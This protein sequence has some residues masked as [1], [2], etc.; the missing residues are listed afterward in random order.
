MSPLQFVRVFLPFAFGYFISYFFRNVNAIIEQDLVRELGFSAAALGLLT[1]VYFISFAAFQL[2]LGL[3]LDR[4]GP[5]RTESALLLFA[6]LGAFVFS[7]ADSLAGLIVGRLLIGFGVSA[8]LMAAFKAFVLWFP[9]ERLPLMNGLQMVAGG[10]GALSATVPLQQ[11]LEL[12]DWRGVFLLLAGMTV[13]ASAFLWFVLPERKAER[14]SVSLREQLAGLKKVAASPVFWSIAPLTMFSQ[15]AQMAIQGLWAKPWLRD[16]AGLDAD[17]AARHLLWMMVAMMAGFFMLG[18]I[19]E[20]ITRL[21]NIRPTTLGVLA[22]TVFVGLQATMASGWTARPLLLM[23]AF[24]F[25]ATA[26]ILPYAGLSQTF[27]A[28]LSGRANTSLNLLVFVGAFS[29]QWGLGEIINLWPA[30]ATG[31]APEGYRAALGSLA[32]LQIL[33]LLWYAVLRFRMRKTGL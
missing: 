28:E 25:F 2:P 4:F 15:G 6:A 24:S 10:L 3:L 31:Y 7:R 11:A 17:A 14:H 22:M 29:I 5:R 33:G 18:A 20:R 1:S 32:A 19:S 26:G 23:V 8:C 12:T 16:V 27:P 30:T 13:I 9:P 21:W